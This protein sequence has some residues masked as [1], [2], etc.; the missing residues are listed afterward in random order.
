VQTIG[1]SEK[2]NWALFDDYHRK[3]VTTAFA[4]LEWE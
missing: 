2:N 3:N 4:E 1:Y